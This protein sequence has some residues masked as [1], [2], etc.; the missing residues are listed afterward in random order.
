MAFLL[1][2]AM[3]YDKHSFKKK[4]TI[5]KETSFLFLS[6]MIGHKNDITKQGLSILA[7]DK[8]NRRHSR[9]CCHLLRLDLHFL[10]I[11]T[12]GLLY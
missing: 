3:S 10:P 9:K 5:T 4:I 11:Q 6:G 7:N 2:D 12:I 1:S 8:K